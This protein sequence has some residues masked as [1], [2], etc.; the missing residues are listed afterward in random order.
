MILPL[1]VKPHIYIWWI[2]LIFRNLSGIEDHLGYDIPYISLSY[3]FPN[4][5]GGTKFHDNHHL[6]FNGNYASFFV[7]ID[8][9]FCT[10]IKQQSA[11]RG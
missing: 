9:V 1:F 4:I 3:W 11:C 2:Y 10:E 6:Y 8:K 7:I 5:F